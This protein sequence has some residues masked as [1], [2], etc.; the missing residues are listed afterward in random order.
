MKE[1]DKIVNAHFFNSIGLS[2][3]HVLNN[4]DFFL[5]FK[6]RNIQTVFTFTRVWQ[7]GRHELDGDQGYLGVSVRLV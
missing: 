2:P 7:T 4:D 5:F 3:S 6:E 1:N